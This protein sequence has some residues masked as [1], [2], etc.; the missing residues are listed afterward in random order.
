MAEPYN[1]AL[2]GCGTVGGGVAIIGTMFF[3]VI[4]YVV[5]KSRF[6][7]RALMDLLSWLPWAVPG[8]VA[9]E[10]TNAYNTEEAFDRVMGNQELP[11]TVPTRLSRVP[12]AK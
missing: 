6:A 7:G 2:I 5:V 8:M 4:A 9:T 11:D 1:I 3:G 10:G 12:P